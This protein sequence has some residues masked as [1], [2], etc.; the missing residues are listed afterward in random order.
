MADYLRDDRSAKNDAASQSSNED[1]GFHAAEQE[2]QDHIMTI[3]GSTDA[4]NDM[5]R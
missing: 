3:Y 5:F 1:D 2:L 4:N